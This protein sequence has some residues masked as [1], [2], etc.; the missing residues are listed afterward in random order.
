MCHYVEE[1]ELKAEFSAQ[2]IA[3]YCTDPSQCGPFSHT[4]KASLRSLRHS[5]VL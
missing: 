2:T 4:K 3:R 1:K 5:K